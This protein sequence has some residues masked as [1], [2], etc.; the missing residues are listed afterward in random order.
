MVL[1]CSV[2]MDISKCES[3]LWSFKIIILLSLTLII[4]CTETN[5]LNLELHTQDFQNWTEYHHYDVMKHFLLKLK[6]DFQ[7]LANVYTIGQSVN[8]RELY[9]IRITSNLSD[10]YL[11]KPMFKYVANLHGNEAVGRE[12][13]LQLAYYLLY[14]YETSERVKNIVDSVDIHLMPSANPDGFELAKEGDCD[15]SSKPSGRENANAVDLNR[16]FP[17]QFIALNGSVLTDGRQPETLSLMSWIV[18]NPFVLSANLHGGAIVA[19]Y[20]FD[21]SKFHKVSGYKSVSPD[22]SLFQHLASIYSK[23]HSLMAK[24]NS[25]PDDDFPGGITNGAAWYDVTGGMQDFNYVYS[26]C[27]EITLELS[28]CKYPNATS[29]P[30]EW[31]NNK[32]SLLS[33]I[34]QVHMG[35]TGTIKDSETERGVDLAYIHVSGIKHN[36]TTAKNGK[37]WRLLLPGVYT[38]EVSSYGY[39]SEK[40]LVVVKKGI[41]ELNFVL[42]QLS[43]THQVKEITEP[44]L[45]SSSFPKTTA[46]PTDD[47]TSKMPVTSSN[48][49]VTTQV[50]NES[51][52]IEFKHH[53]YKEMVAILN[54]VKEKCPNITHLYS[55]GKSVEGRELFVLELTDNPGV[56]EPGEPEFKYIANMHGNEVIGREMLLLLV[57][58]FCEMY[59]VDERVTK[60][61]QSTR[62]HIMPSM[63]PDGYEQSK[64]RDF[65]GSQGRENANG[66]DLNRNFPDQFRVTKDNEVQQPETSA[67]MKWIL[68]EP[69]VL[70]AN[71]HGGSLVAN[72][73]FDDNIEDKDGIYSKSPD[74]ALFR[75][76][77]SVYSNKHP[78][79]HE[80][81]PCGRGK[82][83]ETFPGGITNGAMWYSVSGGMQD[84]NYLHSN[85]F[86]ITLE[87]GC[88]KYPPARDLSVYW[89]DNK[90][91][92]ISFIEQVHTGVH[93]FILDKHGTGIANATIHVIGIDHDVKSAEA[94]DYWRLLN[95]GKYVI[96]A[97][98]AGYSHDSKEIIVPDESGIQI[99]FTLDNAYF[100]WSQVEDFGILDSLEERYINNFELHNQLLQLSNEHPDLV[101]PMANFGTGGLKALNFI[102]ISS[103]INKSDE[104]PQVAVLGHLHV[105]QLAGRE[106]CLRLARHLVEGYKMNDKNIT[107][108]LSRIAVHIIPSVDN[109]EVNEKTSDML[110]YGD[111]FGDDYN[112]MFDPVEGIKSN[113]NSYHYSSLISL[114]GNGLKIS[115]P[116]NAIKDV[117]SETAKTFKYAS[118]MFVL[119]HPLISKAAMCADINNTEILDGYSLQDYAFDHHGTVAIAAHVSCCTKPE[120]HDLPSLWVNNMKSLMQFL[121]ASAQGVSGHVVDSYGNPMKNATVKLLHSSSLI[122]VHSKTGYFAVNLMPGSYIFSISCHAHESV[123]QSVIVEKDRFSKLDIVMDPVITNIHTH[124]YSSIVLPLKRIV[125]HYPAITSLYSIGKNKEDH[126]LWVLEIG[127]QNAEQNHFFPAVRLLAG[128]SGYEAINAE[129]LIQL[130]EYLVMHYGKDTIV[131]KL[132]EKTKIYIA[133]SLNA[134]QT[135]EKYVCGLERNLKYKD[136]NK[137]FDEPSKNAAKETNLIKKWILTKPASMSLA[138]FSGAEV[139]AYPLQYPLSDRKISKEEE[140]I[141]TQLSKVYSGSHPRMYKGN[142]TCASQNYSFARGIAKAS[143][144]HEHTGSYIDFGY[145]MT[146]SYDI[147]VYVSCCSDSKPEEMARVWSE[148][149]LPLLNFIAQVHR[150]ITGFIVSNNN[151][152][153]QNALISIEGFSRCFASDSNGFYHLILYPG[154]YIIM[155]SRDHYLPLKKVI[156]VYPGEATIIDFQLQED[157]QI[158]GI[159]QHSFIIIFG[160]V[161]VFL[162]VV[163][164]CIY[165]ITI[166]KRHRGYAFQKLEQEHFLHEDEMAEDLKFSTSKGLLKNSDY[167]DDSTSEDEL[168]N[169]YAWKN[170]RR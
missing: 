124:D 106:L 57:Q 77:A 115:L 96:L 32:E 80:A 45:K 51:L 36:V 118:K 116:E 49:V 87:L 30:K 22:D 69:F 58:Y 37:Y 23:S 59:N 14:N 142:F 138:L 6:D 130:A 162:L 111:K 31:E 50:S 38:V 153:I 168:Y 91:P 62:I 160:S 121:Y 128:L 74:D 117:N 12:L 97:S 90:E 129:I 44:S 148:H 81:K 156:H 48:I 35:I 144:L 154:E 56:H 170:G 71:L 63:N 55:I 67:V 122:P 46:Q 152:P 100:S 54:R 105:N 145:K 82:M 123:M 151:K 85:C 139:V 52:P 86:E 26:N 93:G 1:S 161:V 19:S 79:M 75:E 163:S 167:H 98:I 131:T 8:K 104:K 21:D 147:A 112:G 132:L 137:N 17:D 16:D 84:W 29:L 40:K 68:S 158:V 39:K 135:D 18:N 119:S 73:P 114:E 66:I 150:G 157:A 164:I 70:S 72:Y 165:S 4:D 64:E 134:G 9:V 125:A 83:N 65:D 60:L 141:F 2:V 126:D 89:Q 20:P 166:Y 120:P 95:P 99:N 103:E 53:H 136:L 101:K 13:L 34:E 113:L 25:C 127:V 5:E 28:C 143:L 88:Y 149:K 41:E 92:L 78:K 102:I 42:Q 61:L 24:G 27:F 140:N 108:L 169:T 133:P 47:T 11:S 43:V 7:S 76:L 109:R 94:G 33:F 110:D 107:E 155:I 146:H 3:V 10:T 159:P 15:G